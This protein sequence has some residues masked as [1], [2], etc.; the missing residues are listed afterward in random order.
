MTCG[1]TIFGLA[2][3]HSATNERGRVV[4]YKF[5]FQWCESQGEPWWIKQSREDLGLRKVPSFGIVSVLIIVK[6]VV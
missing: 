6:R 2:E 3:T 1:L 4:R 5:A